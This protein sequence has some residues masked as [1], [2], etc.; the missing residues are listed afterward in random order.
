MNELS[1]YTDKIRVCFI[2]PEFSYG[3][4]QKQCIFL[5]NALQLRDDVEVTLIR[6]RPGPLDY[7]LRLDRLQIKYVDVS[8]NY[9]LRVIFAVRRIVSESEADVII[10]WL[11]VSDVYS[12]FV[13]LLRPGLKWIMTQRNSRPADSWLRPV[14]NILGRR[15]DAIAANSPGG[16]SYWERRNARGPLYLVNNI[17][18]SN[19]DE[20]PE[21]AD[22]SVLYVGRLEQQK[23]VLTLV[24]AFVLT[25]KRYPDAKVW[26]CGDG[27]LRREMEAIVAE[28]GVRDRIEFL[29]FR[30]DAIEWMSRAKILVS[31]SD[32]EGMPN[33]L[34]EAVGAGCVVIASHI[35]EHVDF[36]GA[37]YPLL[38]R[39]HHDAGEVGDV[40]EQALTSPYRV[41]DFDHARK[42]LACM[43]PA[44]VAESYMNIFRRTLAGDL[45]QGA[46][47]V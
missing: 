31:L 16:V 7:L 5:L 10:S 37:G 20:R 41:G 35:P 39:N 25:V 13:R 3:G 11:R 4:A 21:R 29:G 15:A 12:Y 26:V 22:Q 30:T 9:D 45:T 6:F 27:S 17:A 28:H 32:H 2:I 47:D 36:L 8:S 34:M 40:I 1:S 42:Q 24:E 46:P 23:N 43:K 19:A 33:V 18:S 38:V 44:T 14:R